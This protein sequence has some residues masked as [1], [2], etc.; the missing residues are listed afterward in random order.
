MKLLEDLD[1]YEILELDVDATSEQV[2]KAYRML[3]ATY[4][5]DSLAVYSL[6]DSSDVAAMNE[7]VESAYQLLSN[8]EQRQEY[9]QSLKDMEESGGNFEAVSPGL[10]AQLGDTD[11]QDEDEVEPREFDGSGLRGA[12]ERKSISLEQVA[13]MTKINSTYLRWIEDNSYD[14]L[15]ALV[16]VR[17]FV[18]SYARAIGLDPERVAASYMSHLEQARS[19]SSRGRRPGGK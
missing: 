10:K 17:G 14:E 3:Q 8:E 18:T 16:Y 19:D 1:H 9:D 7:R 13:S 15:P 2:E 4:A 12:R 5:P 11:S 6:L